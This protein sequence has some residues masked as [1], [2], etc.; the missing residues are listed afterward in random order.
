MAAGVLHKLVEKLALRAG[1]MAEDG[2]EH[3]GRKHDHAHGSG[4]NRHWSHSARS[5]D[6][7]DELRVLTRTR[8]MR[9][10]DSVGLVVPLRQ[11]ARISVAGGVVEP[12]CELAR[13]VSPENAVVS[14]VLVRS[15]RHIVSGVMQR[16]GAGVASATAVYSSGLLFSSPK[17]SSL[18]N[19]VEHPRLVVHFIRALWRQD[20]DYTDL[21]LSGKCATGGS[22]EFRCMVLEL[23]NMSNA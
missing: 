4:V 16:I 23:T 12:C 20:C 2:S 17:P 1:M 18:F 21:H 14:S 11:V 13:V 15:T 5:E 22:L 8:C 9:V 3:I 10:S 6:R 19:I 7:V